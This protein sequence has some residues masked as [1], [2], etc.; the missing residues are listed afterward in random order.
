MTLHELV[1][2]HNA[3]VAR[4]QAMPLPADYEAEY[5]LKLREARER[6]EVAIRRA[7]R[8]ARRRRAQ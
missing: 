6:R 7:V 4:G 1:R 3:Q 8:R 5:E 2:E